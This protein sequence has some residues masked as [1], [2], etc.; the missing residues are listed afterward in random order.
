MYDH[1]VKLLLQARKMPPVPPPPLRSS[2]SE[3][4]E[5]L[6]RAVLKMNPQHA[7]AHSY[8]GFI[9]QLH[10]R[11]HAAAEMEYRLAIKYDPEHPGAHH[12]LGVILVQ[13]K[14]DFVGAIAQFRRVLEIDSNHSFA[15]VNLGMILLFYHH[16]YFGAEAEYQASIHFR[17]EVRSATLLSCQMELQQQLENYIERDRQ[18]N[19]PT[20]TVDA[21][22]L[23]AVIE[24]RYPEEVTQVNDQTIARE[25]AEIDCQ[26]ETLE[27][28]V[29]EPEALQRKRRQTRR[30]LH[31]ATG[32]RS[33]ARAAVLSYF[34][35]CFGVRCR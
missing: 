7:L 20:A 10:K 9:L 3:H 13:H 23:K 12:N 11:D 2:L 5:V 19:I 6:L 17:P 16:D 29:L 15:H 33:S 34:R 21:V 28:E 35:P 26:L 25:A 8:L 18:Q 31:R 32:G 22:D 1:A 30:R 27:V 24:R 4:A 14:G